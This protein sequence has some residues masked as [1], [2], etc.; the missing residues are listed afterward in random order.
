M[1]DLSATA[2]I[3]VEQFDVLFEDLKNWGRWGQED[4]LGTLNFL[5]PAEVTRACGLVRQGRRV[6]LGQPLDTFPGPENPYPALHYMTGMADPSPTEPTFYTDFVG[7]DFHGHSVSHIDALCHS[8]YKGTFYNG[9]QCDQIISTSGSST[10]SVV[11]LTDGIVGRGVLLDVPRALGVDWIEPPFALGSDDLENVASLLG[12][13]MRRGD[14]VLVRTGYIRRRNTKGPWSVA[15]S[16]VGLHVSAMRWLADK[17]A[18]VLGGDGDRDAHPSS[19]DGIDWPIHALA[20]SAM[21]MP[22]L[23]NLDLETL[24]SVCAQ[25]VAFE[26]LMA[27][28]PLIIPGGTGSPVNPVAIL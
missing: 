8:G 4:Q 11:A 23:D 5:G 15:S 13:E 22:L 7:T 14:I 12:V 17:E 24:S 20:L 26:F 9:K 19:V 6:S 21:G 10:L 27:V 18:A 25:A 16:C 3:T 1:T 28:A 2:K